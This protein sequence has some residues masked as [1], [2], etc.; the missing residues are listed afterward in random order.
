MIRP[1]SNCK[2]TTSALEKNVISDVSKLV[3]GKLEVFTKPV[4]DALGLA[5]PIIKSIIF[6][7]FPL[8]TKVNQL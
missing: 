2:S 7:I 8:I 5:I 6:L 3:A 4:Q 1:G